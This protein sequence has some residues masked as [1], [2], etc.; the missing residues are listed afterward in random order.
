MHST[1]LV[2]FYPTPAKLDSAH[3]NVDCL[4]ALNGV[5]T[6]RNTAQFEV[7]LLEN[8]VNNNSQ[9]QPLIHTSLATFYAKILLLK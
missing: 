5:C 2:C 1:N 8:E 6:K 3:P 7:L 9:T 4:A